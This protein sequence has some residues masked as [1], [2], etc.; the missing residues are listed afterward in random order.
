M[1]Y[2]VV[3]KELALPDV[4]RLKA[5]FKGFPGLTPVDAYTVAKDAFGILLKG[6]T[7]EN[8]NRM[9]SALQ[10]Q[11]IETEVVD[12][13]LLPKMP[14]GPN[15]T[16]ID[17]D[18]AGLTVY[19][20]INRPVPVEWQKVVLIAAGRVPLTEFK[21]IRTETQSTEFDP[22][23]FARGGYGVRPRMNVEYETKEERQEHLLLEIILRGTPA[24]YSVDVGRSAHLLFGCLGERKSSN[25]KTN[26]TLLIQDL[27]RFVPHV[28]IN[29][30]AYYFR[31]NAAEPFVYPSKNAF[32]EEMIWLLWKLQQAGGKG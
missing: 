6:Y 2:A 16:R 17:F 25:L 4:E 8:A 3:Q 10:A 18:P 31:E 7:Y 5:A 19:D 14:Q 1:P 22:S 32:Y 26:L 11:G 28:A 12:E 30:G 9:V 21:R 13:S 27:L 24:R 20:A 29:Q 15:T 23:H